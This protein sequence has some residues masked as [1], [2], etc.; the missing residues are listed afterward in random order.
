MDAINVSSG[1][2]RPESMRAH[3]VPKFLP[4]LGSGMKLFDAPMTAAGNSKITAQ[5][6]KGRFSAIA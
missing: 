1:G 2:G 6:D 4:D 5:S 3:I